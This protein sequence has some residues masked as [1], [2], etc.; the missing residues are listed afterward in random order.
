METLTTQID[1]LDFDSLG[2]YD[3]KVELFDAVEKGNLDEIIELLS[4]LEKI[5][6]L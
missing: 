5:A 3:I 1:R 2:S 6:D 4:K